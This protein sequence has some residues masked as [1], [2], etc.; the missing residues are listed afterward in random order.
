MLGKY[1]KQT[2]ETILLVCI[3]CFFFKILTVM[4]SKV[5]HMS[6]NCYYSGSDNKLCIL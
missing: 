3:L 4:A 6:Q 5:S 2:R 1:V